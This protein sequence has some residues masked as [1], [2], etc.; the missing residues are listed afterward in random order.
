MKSIQ[1][2]VWL[3]TN[4]S[5]DECTGV[6]LQDQAISHDR[7]FFFF[8]LFFVLGCFHLFVCFFLIF[9]GSCYPYIQLG[10]VQNYSHD[11]DDG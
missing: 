11:D 6:S 10:T 3:T 5:N 9:F 7:V 8:G 2:K 1:R 4:N